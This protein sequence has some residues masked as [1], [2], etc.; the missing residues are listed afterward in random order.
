METADYLVTL[1][2]ANNSLDADLSQIHQNVQKL[3]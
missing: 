3:L 1:S 2:L